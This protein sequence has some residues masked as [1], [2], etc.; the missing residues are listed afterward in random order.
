M[1][2]DG[3]ATFRVAFRGQFSCCHVL[4]G[5]ALLPVRFDRAAAQVDRQ[6]CLSYQKIIAGR[7]V[8]PSAWLWQ[9]LRARSAAEEI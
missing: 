2:W 3:S 8:T 4:V 9:Y 5:Q 1:H 7:G 6:E